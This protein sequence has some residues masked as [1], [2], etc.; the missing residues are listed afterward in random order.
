MGV[1]ELDLH[2]DVG[3]V[4]SSGPLASCRAPEPGQ[5]GARE[6]GGQRGV[7]QRIDQGQLVRTVDVAEAVDATGNACLPARADHPSAERGAVI[8]ES[9]GSVDDDLGDLADRRPQPRPEGLHDL[10]VMVEQVPGRTVRADWTAAED[11]AR[12]RADPSTGAGRVLHCLA[13]LEQRPEVDDPGHERHEQGGD[14]GELDG[15]GP[16]LAP[17]PRETVARC[18]IR[19]SRRAQFHGRDVGS[20]DRRLEHR[21]AVDQPMKRLSGT[22]RTTCSSSR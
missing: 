8:V 21:S 22:C 19:C 17:E 5:V 4:G 6:P 12:C 18:P 2:A 10:R 9:D 14:D 7:V 3:V 13:L 20:P 16:S 15:G 11:G 1:A